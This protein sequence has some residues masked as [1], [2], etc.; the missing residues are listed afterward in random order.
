MKKLATAGFI[1]LALLLVGC[2]DEDNTSKPFTKADRDRYNAKSA[3]E[4]K[5]KEAKIAE[6]KNKTQ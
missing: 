2:S 4:R 5:Q 1:I 3:E 6:E